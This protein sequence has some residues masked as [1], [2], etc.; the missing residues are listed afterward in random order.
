MILADIDKRKF[1]RSWVS[2]KKCSCE[3]QMIAALLA[4]A[5]LA[6][7][8]GFVWGWAWDKRQGALG[9]VG[10]LDVLTAIGTLSAAGVALYLAGRADKN[11]RK[12]NE[13]QAS[14]YAVYL[15]RRLE[16]VLAPLKAAWTGAVFTS[17]DGDAYRY[18]RFV[19]DFSKVSMEVAL[20]D[21]AKL[22][23]MGNLAAQRIAM[24]MADI[25]YLKFQIQEHEK[26]PRAGSS[27]DRVVD[28]WR[29]VASKASDCLSAAINSLIYSSAGYSSQPTGEEVHGDPEFYGDRDRS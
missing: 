16:P 26:K 8:V 2:R 10:M 7:S 13:L 5:I 17:L 18:Q 24:A 22:A 9:D 3:R 14:V 11:R 20:E 6:L 28:E 29:S 4:G 12:E 21:V 15:A 19:E 25:E 23:A 27:D 1:W